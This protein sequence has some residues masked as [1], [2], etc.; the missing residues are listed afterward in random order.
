MVHLRCASASSRKNATTLIY[1]STHFQSSSATAV[2][3]QV[4]MAEILCQIPD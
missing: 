3:S 1:C 2:L 4:E